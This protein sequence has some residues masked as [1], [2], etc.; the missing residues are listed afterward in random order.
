MVTEGELGSKPL[1]T[2]PLSLEGEESNSSYRAPNILQRILSLL[3]TVRPGSDLTRLQ[4]PPI[5]NIPKSQLQCYGESVYCI[6]SDMLSKCNNEKSPLNR[7]IS[8]V[9]WSISTLRPLAFGV[10]P[11]NPILGETHHVSRGSLNVFLEQV[12]HHPPVAALHAT[13][14]TENIELLWCHSP[15]AKFNGSRIETEVH[16]KR[17]L[18]LVDKNETYTMNSPK[19]VIKFLPLPGVD[20]LGNVKI[21]CQENGFE[22][23][24]CYRGVTFLPRASM[25]RSI[26]GK[27]FSSSS[28]E[29]IYE[30]SGHWD[31]IVSI[32]DV[33][34]GKATIIYNASEAIS[35]LQTPAVKDANAVSPSES[36]AVWAEVGRNII[37]KNW[38]K[39]TEAKTDIEERQRELAKERQSAHE[40]WVPKHF[41]VSYSKENGWDCLPKHKFVT[42]APIICTP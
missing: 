13:D 14:E 7:F 42:P 18:K 34:N 2:A 39:A 41:T 15:V 23:E 26:R 32:K 21:Q 33:S 12:S 1:L 25:H 10:A 3:N 8:V 17:V 5:F 36:T 24:L 22:A 9:A 37:Q 38:E 11:Y 16:G 31:S 20:W 27:I 4:L 28:L 35:R 19:L 30:I 40:D 6:S 29:T